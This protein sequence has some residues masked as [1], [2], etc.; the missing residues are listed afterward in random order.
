MLMRT[1]HHCVTV[2][3]CL[4]AA[5]K[6]RSP[7][8]SCEVREP[9]PG[10]SEYKVTAADRELVQQV[11]D[12]LGA[13]KPQGLA[14]PPEVF[15]TDTPEIQACAVPDTPSKNH[16]VVYTGLLRLVVQGK[17]DRLA[18]MLGHEFSH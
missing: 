8:K 7:R 14:W 11:I 5:Q 13:V 9:D 17:P 2:V 15:I 12:R 6:P 1:R 18:M 16:V 3:I 10:S 4:L